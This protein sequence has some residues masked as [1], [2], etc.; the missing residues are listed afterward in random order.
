MQDINYPPGDFADR[1]HATFGPLVL[2]PPNQGEGLADIFKVSHCRHCVWE[3]V[4]VD[5]GKHRENGMDSNRF[6]NGNHIKRLVVCAG[7]QGTAVYLKCGWQNNKIDDVLIKAPYAQHS[8]WFEGDYSSSYK[9][10]DRAKTWN[11]NNTYGL[12]RREDGKP[13]RVRWNFLRGEQPKFGA[14]SNIEYQWGW[15]LIS[16]IYTELKHLCT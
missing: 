10:V 11:S 12:V 4:E 1:L 7:T 13:V 14:G 8:D 6:S 15:S 9:D 5:A 16:T 2:I 3:S